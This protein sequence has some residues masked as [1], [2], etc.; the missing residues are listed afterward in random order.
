VTYPD[1]TTN[2]FLQDWFMVFNAPFNNISV[3][4][5]RLVLLVEEIRIPRETQRLAE[6][7]WQT[8]SHNFVSST[9]LHEQDSNSL[10]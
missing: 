6:S 8:E 2:A 3:I 9:P 4:L 7:Y 5:L 1:E 10:H